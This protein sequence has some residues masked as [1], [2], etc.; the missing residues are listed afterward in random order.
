MIVISQQLHIIQ[1]SSQTLY[2][3]P[4]IVERTFLL[5][6]IDDNIVEFNEVFQ[7]FLGEPIGG[8]RL[9]PQFRTNIIIIDNDYNKLDPKFTRPVNGL[10]CIK[11]SDL[12]GHLFQ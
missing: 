5:R 1:V 4:G 6:I 11:T 7:V 3:Y 10:N 9:G 2:F 8:G 12:L